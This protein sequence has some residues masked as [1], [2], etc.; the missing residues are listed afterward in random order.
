M[1]GKTVGWTGLG[2]SHPEINAMKPRTGTIL[3]S[4]RMRVRLVEKWN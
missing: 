4:V 2:R 3:P 1:V